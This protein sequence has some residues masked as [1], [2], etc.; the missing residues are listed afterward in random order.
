MQVIRER[1]GR[2]RGSGAVWIFARC[3]RSTHEKVSY[4]FRGANLEA[5]IHTAEIENTERDF[6]LLEAWSSLLI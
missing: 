2:K 6:N 3:S 1:T 4:H 5:A